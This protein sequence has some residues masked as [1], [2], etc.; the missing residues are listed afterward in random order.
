M[1]S[2]TEHLAPDG[3]VWPGEADRGAIAAP[4]G[5]S[6]LIRRLLNPALRLWLRSQ[7]E[8]MEALQVQI[9]GSDRQIL[10]GYLPQVGL[11]A[12]KVV[13][14]GLH[15][16]QVQ[17]VGRHIRCNLGQVLQGQPLK[18]LE[19]VSLELRVGLEV[20]DLNA[21]LATPLL[22]NALSELLAK[23]LGSMGAIAFAPSG[24]GLQNPECW[25][26]EQQFTLKADLLVEGTPRSVLFRTGLHLAD[27]QTLQLTNPWWFVIPHAVVGEPKSWQQR[28][29]PPFPTGPALDRFPTSDQIHL[30]SAVALRSLCLSPEQILCEGEVTVLP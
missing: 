11:A 13:Y 2:V 21:S 3:A 18:L 29:A 10:S 27:P 23:Y 6:H 19:P 20:A 14:R 7:V 30:G 25:L 22:T 8:Q 17:L 15:L 5:Q 28:S 9:Q 12:R 1:E 26:G 4:G 24:E 16:S